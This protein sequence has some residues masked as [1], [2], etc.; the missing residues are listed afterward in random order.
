MSKGRIFAGK[1]VILI[2]AQDQLDKTLRGVENKMKRLSNTLGAMG[3]TAFTGG[4]LSATGQGLLIKRFAKYDDLMLE[5]RVKM[6]MLNKTTQAQEVTFARLE[7]R[8]RNLGKSTSFTTQEIAE[9]AI[10]LAQAGF[11]G[12][13]VEDSLQAVLDLSRGTRTELGEAGRV[14]ANT[15]RTFSLDTE[16]ANEVVSSFVVAARM[17]TVELDDLAESLK[18]SSS[19]AVEL[20]QSLSGVLAIFTL[21]SER[22]MR[23]SIAGTSLNT[24]MANA[25]KKAGDIAD[26]YGFEV[27]TDQAGNLKFVDFLNKLNDATKNMGSMK[28]VQAFQDLFNLRGGRA[29]IPLVDEAMI[30]RLVELTN[31]IGRAGDEAKQAAVIMDSGLGGSARRATSALED[32]N[33]TLGKIQKGPLIG[34]LNSVPPLANAFSVLMRTNQGLILS[35]AALPAALLASGGAMLTFSFA[36][37]RVAGIISTTNTAMKA[38]L[39]FASQGLLPQA[40]KAGGKALPGVKA[41]ATKATSGIGKYPVGAASAVPGMT[42]VTSRQVSTPRNR[43]EASDSVTTGRAASAKYIADLELQEKRAASKFAAATKRGDSHAMQREGTKRKR[44]QDSLKAARTAGPKTMPFMPIGKLA[45]SADALKSTSTAMS[46]TSTAKKTSTMPAML[47]GLGKAGGAVRSLA[48]LTK[49]FA[50][51]A[52]AIGKFATKT[53]V[54]MIALQVIIAFG[55]KIP[56]IAPL[57]SNVGKSFSAFFSTI[58]TIGSRLGPV[59]QLMTQSFGLLGNQATAGLGVEGIIQSLTSMGSIVGSTLVEAWNRFKETLGSVYDVL[60]KT[61]TV[62]WELGKAIFSIVTESLG[63]VIGTALG[64]IGANI[65]AFTS[66]FEGGGGGFIEGFKQVVAALSSAVL[67]LFNWVGFFVMKATNMLYNFIDDFNMMLL[68]VIGKLAEMTP[69]MTNTTGAAIETIRGEKSRRNVEFRRSTMAN[70]ETAAAA[71]DRIIQSLGSDPSKEAGTAANN[72]ESEAMSEMK[73]VLRYMKEL[74]ARAAGMQPGQ[75]PGQPNASPQGSQQPV[76]PPSIA[77]VQQWR[78]FVAALVGTAA[79]TRGNTL[80]SVTET[81]TKKQTNILE[82]IRDNTSKSANMAFS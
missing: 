3:R 44:I 51:F 61:V 77:E 78:G 6:G 15:M 14:M 28:R 59:F 8:I 55:D 52:L 66:M 12:K 23:G 73:S 69:F 79:S 18:Y 58:G 68:S 64:G 80:R 30:D 82:D 60:V 49:G 24:A 75:T 54:L 20:G 76:T 5:L 9:G 10:R 74:A 31:Q 32:L 19:T 50:S 37:R 16:T 36:L 81:E 21:L 57:L 71:I 27:P 67:E 70:D 1:A 34:I 39:G 2:Q 17:G 38:M 26:K 11:S 33:I 48:G 7:K 63:N 40:I 22:G 42:A 29:I 45:G 53:N 43:L 4:F 41:A 35:I 46:V 72:A 65:S 25:S 56:F 13:E 62:V 47:K